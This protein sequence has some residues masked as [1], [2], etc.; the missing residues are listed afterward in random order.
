MGRGCQFIVRKA[1]LWT[2]VGNVLGERHAPYTVKTSLIVHFQQKS[3][4]T[5]AATKE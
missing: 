3:R 5:L 2:I 1:R 4:P